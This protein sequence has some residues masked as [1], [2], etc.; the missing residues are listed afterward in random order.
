MS[1][2]RSE[3]ERV[4]DATERALAGNLAKGAGKLAE[5]GKRFVRDRLALLLDEGSF[6]E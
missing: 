1:D 3:Y 5:Q 6:V 2:S 4:A